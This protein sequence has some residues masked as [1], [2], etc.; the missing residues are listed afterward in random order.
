MSELSRDDVVGI[1]GPIGDVAAA[2]IIATGISKDELVAAKARVIQD[3]K[4]HDPG[5]AMAPGPFAQT[6]EILER[7]GRGGMFGEAGSTLS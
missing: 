7:L 6:V 2:E 1:V 4:T 3:R 5:S